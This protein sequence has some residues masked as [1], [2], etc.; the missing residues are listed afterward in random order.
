VTE[1]ILKR[2]DALAAKLG[3]AAG[4]LWRILVTQAKVEA[5]I[6]AGWS[7]VFAIATAVAGGFSYWLII[8]AI[9]RV[10]TDSDD[11]T[12]GVGLLL[13]LLSVVLLIMTFG[14]AQEAASGFLNPEY[15]ALKLLKEALNQ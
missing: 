6:S 11:S 7:V 15:Q 1:E 12:G 5:W 13:G 14:F 8:S 9:R 2:V 10:R 3:V 4:E